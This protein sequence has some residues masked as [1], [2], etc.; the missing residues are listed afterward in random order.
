M[1]AMENLSKVRMT[2]LV[3]EGTG[4]FYYNPFH[5]SPLVAEVVQDAVQV[6]HT[7]GGWWRMRN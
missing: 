1:I 7:L 5:Y 4:R 2:S 6:N 3:Y